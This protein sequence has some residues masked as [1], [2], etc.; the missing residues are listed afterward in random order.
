MRTTVS[1]WC[2]LGARYRWMGSGVTKSNPVCDQLTAADNRLPAPAALLS[3][4]T[5]RGPD[6]A[7]FDSSHHSPRQRDRRPVR[8]A[9]KTE[10]MIR[11]AIAVFLT[12]GTTQTLRLEFQRCPC[13]G[14]RNSVAASNAER[15]ANFMTHE[16]IQLAVRAAVRG[17]SDT[18]RPTHR[19]DGEG[20]RVAGLE[21]R[22]RGEIIDIGEFQRV[23]K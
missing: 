9:V 20:L 10:V 18:L 11:R 1:Y 4:V 19:G 12:V 8:S 7:A 13:Q 14:A 21:L 5:V 3:L 2:G 16:R 17:L 15:G 23:S 22:Q 6:I